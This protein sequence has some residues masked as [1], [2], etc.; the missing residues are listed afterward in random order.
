LE[1]IRFASAHAL[2]KSR[3]CFAALS[4]VVVLCPATYLNAANRPA[5]PVVPPTPQVHADR[6]VTFYFPDPGAREVRLS[7]AGYAH[8]LAMKKSAQGVWSVTVGPLAP[9]IYSYSFIADGIPRMDPSNHRLVQNLLWPGNF[10]EVAGPKPE[11]WDIQ[12]V[13]HGVVHYHIYH[14]AIVGDNRGYY[15][16]TPPGYDPRA[17]Q[18]YPVLYL[19]HGYSDDAS[20]WVKVGRANVIL[21]NLIAGGD[22][23]P[24]IVVMPL[25]YGAPAIVKGSHFRDKVLRRKNFKLFT[26]TL[27][28]EVIPRVQA[29]YRVPAYRNDRAIAGLSMGGAE[30]LLTGLNHIDKF[31]WVGSFSAGGLRLNFDKEFPSLNAESGSKLRLLWIA[32]GKDDRYVDHPPLIEVNRK[33]VTWLRTK[34]APVTFVETPGMHEW[35]V[36]RDN[37]IHFAPLLFRDR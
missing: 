9:E 28:N 3:R 1:S 21:D 12:N 18:T 29:E 31:A 26:E 37:L 30:S 27:L 33:L 10:F 5:P 25:G 16:Y 35:L 11:P 4:I 14:S 15:V 20:A 32:C 19:L 13:P 22:T 2:R 36:W 23:R 24:M 17:D 7:L 34:D 6:T 8:P